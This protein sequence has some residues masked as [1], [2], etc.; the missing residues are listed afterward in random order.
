[1]PDPSQTCSIVVDGADQSAFGLPHFTIAK[2]DVG[3]HA[4]K[5]RLLGVLEHYAPK[6]CV[7]LF[8]LAE[9]YESGADH[10]IDSIHCFINSCKP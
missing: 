3:G 8:T 6:Y 2:N 9:E 10:I 1:M 4:L 7:P 5:V